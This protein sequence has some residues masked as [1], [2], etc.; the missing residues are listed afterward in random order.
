M[1]TP[2]SVL[3]WMANRGSYVENMP[4]LILRIKNASKF[5]ENNFGF[6]DQPGDLVEL[7]WQSIFKLRPTL[8]EVNYGRNPCNSLVSALEQSYDNEQITQFFEKVKAFSLHMTDISCED[9]L[10][11]L[12]RFTLLATFSFSETK[13]TSE[14]WTRILKR[15]SELNLRGIDISDNV[16]ENIRQNLDISLMKLSGNP[17]VHVDEFKKGIE[18]VTVKALVVQELKFTGET[19]AEQFLQVLPQSFPRLKTLV[20]DWNVVDPEV[21]FDD[22]TKKILDQLINVYQ[23]LNLE[24]LAIVAY[25]PNAETKVSIEEMA[26]NLKSAIKEVQLHQFASKG[27]SDGMANFSLIL[28]GSNEKVLKEL[29]EM[30]FSDRSTIPPMGKLLR[31]CEEDIAQIYPAITMDFGGF[32]QTHIRQLYNS[33]SD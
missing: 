33:T 9:L 13:F 11:L 27:L 4:G 3:V 14:E 28:A 5:G 24:A 32:N 18:F 20:W 31:L 17:G 6:K 12:S 15:L 7:K 8:V 23:E 26:R 2:E 16:L 25:T 22:R 19:D 10:K 1:T 21:N 29:F 30:Y